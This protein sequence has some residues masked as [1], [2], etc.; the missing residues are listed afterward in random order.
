MSDTT[1][2]YSVSIPEDLAETVREQVGPGGFSAYVTDALRHRLAM[3][4]L[5]QIV[6][7]HEAR[8]GPLT[9]KDLALADA[10]LAGDAR[11]DQNA[12]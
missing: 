6:E 12:A 3:D 1:R 4:R 2:K 7:D 9:E 11:Q 5:S 8:N 10:L